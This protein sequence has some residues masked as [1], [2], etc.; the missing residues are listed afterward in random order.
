M[1]GMIL[2][3]V[4]ILILD[5]FIQALIVIMPIMIAAAVAA[6]VHA[7]LE[8]AYERNKNRTRRL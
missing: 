6:L 3:G 8:H 5:Y 4:Y 7:L 1:D 2:V